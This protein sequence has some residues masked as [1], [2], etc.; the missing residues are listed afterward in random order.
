MAKP[1]PLPLPLDHSNPDWQGGDSQAKGLPCCLVLGPRP[2]G[3]SGMSVQG[4]RT[5]NDSST[6]VLN[7]YPL[8][9]YFGWLGFISKPVNI[10]DLTR[11]PPGRADV[12]RPTAIL[13]D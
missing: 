1:P 11:W 8:E 12:P 7:I 10:L 9:R 6:Q 13:T 5:Q 2:V 3:P 4:L